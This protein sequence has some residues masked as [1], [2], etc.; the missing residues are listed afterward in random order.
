[1]HDKEILIFKNKLFSKRNLHLNY[2]FKIITLILPF[3]LFFCGSSTAIKNEIL[4]EVSSKRL[5][6]FSKKKKLFNTIFLLKKKHY[7]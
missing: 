1:M 6:G 7:S 3:F 2:I 5:E 4:Y